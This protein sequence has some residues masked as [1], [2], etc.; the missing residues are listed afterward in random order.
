VSVYITRHAQPMATSE[1][2]DDDFRLPLTGLGENQARKLGTKL[3]RAGFCGEVYSSPFHR[4]TQT[5]DIIC[6]ATETEFYVYTG[7]SE[8]GGSWVH[9]MSYETMP[10]NESEYK[11]ISVIIKDSRTSWPDAEETKEDIERRFGISLEEILTSDIDEVLFVSHGA[12]CGAALQ[13]LCGE[14]VD[15]KLQGSAGYYLQY[16]TGLTEVLMDEGPNVQQNNNV[17]HLSKDEITSNQRSV[18]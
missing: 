3:A 13:Y 4:C 7:I 9:E 6:E 5:A 2:S 14:D 8:R 11:N 17:D 15:S 18:Q 10:L 1:F 16:N 12:V